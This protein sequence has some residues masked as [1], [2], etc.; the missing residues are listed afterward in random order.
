MACS[1]EVHKIKI[2]VKILMV[3]GGVMRRRVMH[4]WKL[5]RRKHRNWFPNPERIERREHVGKRQVVVDL[6]SLVALP[7]P[8][9]A[10]VVEHVFSQR[11]QRPEVAL[12]GVSRLARY[13]YETIV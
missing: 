13:F 5:Q 12:A 2:G 9:E 1:A 3:R 4:G 6:D 7:T 8:Q 11:V 10:A